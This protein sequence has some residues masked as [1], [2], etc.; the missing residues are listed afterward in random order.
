MKRLILIS[1]IGALLLAVSCNESS[2]KKQIK[3]IQVNPWEIF[4]KL[5]PNTPEEKDVIGEGSYD[6]HANPI[7]DKFIISPQINLEI[8]EIIKSYGEPDTT[9]D[10]KNV[11]PLVL[12]QKLPECNPIQLQGGSYQYND[13]SGKN[14]DWGKISFIVRNGKVFL[15]FVKDSEAKPKIFAPKNERK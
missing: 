2:S 13:I 10:Y 14:Y 8:N 15:I 11:F 5:V 12:S 3:E 6:V 9:G 1:I 4:Y 7:I